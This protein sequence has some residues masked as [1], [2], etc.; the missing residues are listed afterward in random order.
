MKRLFFCILSIVGLACA[1]RLSAQND[2]VK[3]ALDSKAQ[4]SAKMDG[5]VEAPTV[6]TTACIKP[7]TSCR[8]L[9]P[10]TFAWPT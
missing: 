3:D 8:S 5:F 2:I 7:R 10:T 4:P 1:N 6:Q 9:L